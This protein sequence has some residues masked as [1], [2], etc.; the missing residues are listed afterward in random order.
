MLLFYGT[1][2]D[3]L[4]VNL[5]TFPPLFFLTSF[6]LPAAFIYT[7]IFPSLEGLN[8]KQK[9]FL[10]I[11]TCISYSLPSTPGYSWHHSCSLLL[12]CS[13]LLSSQHIFISC[14]LV[15]LFTSFLHKFS[16]PIYFPHFLFHFSLSSLFLTLEIP[17]PP[18]LHSSPPGS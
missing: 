13:S 7:W 12:L 3:L 14:P 17:L 2:F 5:F 10:I 15:F 16:H 18:I 8:I 1:L 4:P 11:K 6:S 9:R